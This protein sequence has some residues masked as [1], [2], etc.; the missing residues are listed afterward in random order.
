[1]PISLAG[2]AIVGLIAIG[3]LG[4]F[5]LAQPDTRGQT[6]LLERLANR[7]DRAQNIAPQ[8]NK[9]LSDMLVEIRRQPASNDRTSD[10]ETRRQLAI[11]RIERV[12]QTKL[13]S[14]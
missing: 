8:T 4:A 14:Q 9:V 7:I 1:M 6:V 3:I 2:K 10:I 12:L 13:T 11:A 5:R